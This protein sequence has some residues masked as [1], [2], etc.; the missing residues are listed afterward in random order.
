MGPSRRKGPVLVLCSFPGS[1]SL[2]PLWFLLRCLLLTPILPTPPSYPQDR[3]FQVWGYMGL[4][5]ILHLDCISP[6][7]EV[8]SSWVK[9]RKL[10]KFLN[11]SA[12]FGYK[13]QKTTLNQVKSKIKCAYERGR[14]STSFGPHHQTTGKGRPE[15]EVASRM[16]GLRI[17][18]HQGSLSS[19][20]YLGDGPTNLLLR[21]ELLLKG[22][23]GL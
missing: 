21:Q 19:F 17:R 22:D 6:G 7:E 13:W 1:Q 15:I 12:L 20:C 3:Y 14:G 23:P 2:C 5:V 16:A 10:S 8:K 18:P 9:D 11:S 4:Q